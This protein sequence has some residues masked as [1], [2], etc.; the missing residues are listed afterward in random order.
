MNPDL[1]AGRTNKRGFGRSPRGR[2]AQRAASGKAK[3]GAIFS[4]VP[5]VMLTGVTYSGSVAANAAGTTADSVDLYV[6]P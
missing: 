4:R 1:A 6:M 3:T 5:T 2:L